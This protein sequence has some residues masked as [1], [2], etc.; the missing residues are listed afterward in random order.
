MLQK[1]PMLQAHTQTTE[2]PKL[3]P[4]R[5]HI[6][7]IAERLILLS[8]EIVLNPRIIFKS[9]ETQKTILLEE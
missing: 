3:L 5:R 1:F 9:L 2:Q 8:P 7:Q 6:I 4:G